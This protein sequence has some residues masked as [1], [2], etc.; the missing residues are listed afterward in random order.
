MDGW[1]PP[2]GPNGERE[3]VSVAS[4]PRNESRATQA[5]ARDR[6]REKR[7]GWQSAIV[8]EVRPQTPRIN[9]I[10]L[11]PERPFSFLPGQHVR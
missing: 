2:A 6:T 4:L 8:L 1:R 7:S 11:A 9:S 5:A 10:F 3:D